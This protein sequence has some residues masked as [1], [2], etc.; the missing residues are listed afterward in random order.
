M[1]YAVVKFK[2]LSEGTEMWSIIDLVV[3]GYN[4]SG[5]GRGECRN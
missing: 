1:Q 5:E 3:V 2:Y 4:L